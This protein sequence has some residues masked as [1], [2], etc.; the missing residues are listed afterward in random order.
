[1]KTQGRKVGLGVGQRRLRL[2]IDAGQPLTGRQ[3]KGYLLGIKGQLHDTTN[4]SLLVPTLC[5]GPAAY[6]RPGK[7]AA[8]SAERVLVKAGLFG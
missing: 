1:M 4:L 6:D 5:P 8:E 3:A 7:K 2:V